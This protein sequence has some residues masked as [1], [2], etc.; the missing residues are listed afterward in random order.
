MDGNAN[1]VA[2]LGRQPELGRLELE[3]LLG[4]ENV[5]EVLENVAVFHTEHNKPLNINRLGGSKKLGRVLKE[6]T[7]PTKTDTLNIAYM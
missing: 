6:V 7:C 5:R 4:E 1:F 3:S 2:I